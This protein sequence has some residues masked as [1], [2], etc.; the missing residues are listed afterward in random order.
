MS[1]R[2]LSL[3]LHRDEILSGRRRP[4]DEVE[5]FLAAY[6]E[7]A[8]TWGTAFIHRIPDEE[9]R[10]RARSLEETARRDPGY[11]A[12]HPLYGALYAVK[13]N[14]DLKG[15]PTTAACPAFAYTPSRSAA[16]VERLEAAG[17]IAVGKTNL[18]AFATGLVGTRS[19]YG[20]VPNAVDPTR[21]SG[22]SSSGSAVAVA[23]GW[24]PFALGTDTAGSGRVPAGLNGIVGLKPSRGLVS[25]RGVVPACRS[26]DCVSV[27]AATVDD[28]E[29]VRDVIRGHDPEDPW[30]RALA[31]PDDAAPAVFTFG[32]PDPLEFF[33]DEEARRAFQAALARLQA[34]GG[35]AV[36]VDFRPFAE[37]ASLLYQGPWV[38]ERLS[39][40]RSFFEKHSS[41][42]HP[43]VR[44][45]IADAGAHDAAQLFSDQ[46]RLEAL[47]KLVA[48]VWDRIDVMVVPTVPT[49][50]RI[51]D[52]LASPL[53]TNRRLGT[54]TNFVNLLDLAALSV[55]GP[56][57]GDGLPAGITLIQRAGTDLLLADLGARFTGTTR[58]P[59]RGDTADVAVVGAHLSG[60]PLNHQLTDRRAR[61][62]RTC[63]T[64]A[65]YRLY[66]LPGT[67]PPK[68]GL[69]RVPGGGQA[70]EVEV[71][72]MPAAAFGTFVAGIPSPLG[73]GRLE[74]E[75]GAWVQGFLC[76]SWAVE[77]AEDISGHGG[78]RAW[79]TARR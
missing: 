26:L 66:T 68:P 27:F 63:R 9:L 19:P 34:I 77:G 67:T 53:D 29:A 13:D 50:Y 60:Q 47:R 2:A 71:W 4:L 51:E 52:V 6:A 58:E 14:I 5:R 64:A 24:V 55:P 23:R 65:A 73:I 36:P 40:I 69:L 74:L 56:L 46:T 79:L 7:D 18:D 37:T 48:P 35:R 17:A 8:G 15:V 30:S 12:A 32:V 45:I 11:L 54:Y 10:D 76:E 75:D 31:L 39:A 62:L 20:V 25:A 38:A 59:R 3:R 22:G 41:D 43:V 44:D 33:A 70:I 49:V 42:I 57:R 16:V 28:A 72:R 1:L 21:I 61:L 78:W